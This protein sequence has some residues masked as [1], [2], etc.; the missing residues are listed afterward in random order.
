MVH[1]LFRRGGYEPRTIIVEADS[2]T[3]ARGK[4][5]QNTIKGVDPEYQGKIS[6]LTSNVEDGVLDLNRL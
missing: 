5:Q 4:M 6:D 3:E 2:E 1:Y